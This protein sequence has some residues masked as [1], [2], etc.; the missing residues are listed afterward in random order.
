M[1]ANFGTLSDTIQV[2]ITEPGAAAAIA[3][4]SVEYPAIGVAGTGQNASSQL[5]FEVRDATGQPV[6]QD[7]AVTVNFALASSPGGAFLSPLS[8]VTDAQGLVRTSVNSGTVAGVAKVR[9]TVDGSSPLI[10]SEVASVVINGGPPDLEHFS[11]SMQPA[12]FAGRL[13]FGLELQITAYLFDKYSNPVPPGTAVWFSTSMGGITGSAY[14]NAIGQAFAT[15][16]SAAPVPTCADT[17]YAYVTAQTVDEFNSPISAN[18]RVL[19]SGATQIEVVFPATPTFTVSDGGSVPI[20]FYVG[21]DCGNPLVGGTTISFEFEGS[22]GFI[23]ETSILLPDTQSQGATFYAVTAYDPSPG[24]VDPPE[25]VFI[26]VTVTN[27][28]NGNVSFIY[29]GTMD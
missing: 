28:E 23:G 16:Y 1:I 17:G 20:V 18:A 7:N 21:D 29:T 3:L 10:V 12:N 6:S 13:F 5:V 11:L 14:T 27:S 26:K 2:S 22:T 24:D 15:L 19:F 25:N 9:A 4:L 8:V